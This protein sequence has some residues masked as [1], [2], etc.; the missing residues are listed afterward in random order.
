[1][2]LL[3]FSPLAVSDGIL[4][5]NAPSGIP[6]NDDWAQPAVAAANY[7]TE[8]FEPH[9]VT[10]E[11]VVLRRAWASRH[12]YARQNPGLGRLFRRRF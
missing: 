9:A 1:M 4:R 3:F 6:L 8:R 2:Q 11:Y 7:K 12:S 5:P 10:R